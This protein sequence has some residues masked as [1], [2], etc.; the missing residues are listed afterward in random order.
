MARHT[1]LRELTRRTT[2]TPP[3]PPAT[4]GGNNRNRNRNRGPSPSK[5]SK[6]N[7]GGPGRGKNPHARGKDGGKKP[8]AAVPAPP[9]VAD[10]TQADA[11]NLWIEQNRLPYMQGLG[12]SNL[13]LNPFSAGS[14]FD[15]WY[16]TT[17]APGQEAAYNAARAKNPSANL[18]FKDFVAASGAANPAAVRNT[19]AH[20]PG[21]QRQVNP[22]AE[23]GRWLWFD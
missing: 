10:P 6:P 5:P 16:N 2:A 18:T 15:Q 9:T 13:G 20:R 4:G 22:F 11:Y 14:E 3:P 19:Y 7:P 23:Q 17:Y 8:A 1:R 12:Q 21:M